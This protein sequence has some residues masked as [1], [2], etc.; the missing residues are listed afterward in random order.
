MLE[1][2]FLEILQDIMLLENLKIN[3]NTK[4]ISINITKIISKKGL[5]MEIEQLL[6]E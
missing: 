2:A 1:S 6:M 5:I 3:L 4:I